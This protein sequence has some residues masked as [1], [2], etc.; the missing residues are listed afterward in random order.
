V[1][2]LIGAIKEED[3]RWIIKACLLLMGGLLVAFLAV[4]YYRKWFVVEDRPSTG[5]FWTFQ[6]LKQ[7]RDRGELT[8]GEYE[9]LRASLISSFGQP[10]PRQTPS[11]GGQ[12]ASP[13]SSG[14]FDLEKGRQG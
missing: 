1:V 5:Q 8:E 14:N 4:W 12:A 6:D 9:A 11:E 2:D 10:N 13:D 7:M 3:T